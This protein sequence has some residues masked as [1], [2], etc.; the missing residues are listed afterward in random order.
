M[1]IKVTVQLLEDVQRRV[2]ERTM[3]LKPQGAFGRLVRD[4]LDSMHKFIRSVVHVDTGSLKA[5][6][7][8]EWEGG[9]RGEIFTDPSVTNPKS[10]VRPV[11]YGVYENARGGSHAFFDQTVAAAPSMVAKGLRA[12]LD[13]F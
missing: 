8:M 11:I 6:Q 4:I 2:K 12:F 10:G 1:D 13:E 7:R 9:L 3:A 5:A